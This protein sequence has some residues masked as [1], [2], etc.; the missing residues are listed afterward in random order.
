M[1]KTG[2]QIP[3]KTKIGAGFRIVHFGH[4]IINPNAKIGKNFNIYPGV[5][6]GHSEGKMFGSPSI[7]DNVCILSNAIVVGGITVG[8]N[9]VI[10]PNSFVNFD[11]PDNAIVLGNPGKIILK[12]KPSAKYIVFAVS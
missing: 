6:I 2:I 10:A 11:V 1:R 4:I 7:G 8:D 12:D 3:A 9:S 5:T